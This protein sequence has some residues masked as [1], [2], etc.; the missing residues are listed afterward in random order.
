MSIETDL[1]SNVRSLQQ[2]RAEAKARAFA[3]LHARVLSGQE[4][5]PDAP[6]VEESWRLRSRK[7][8]LSAKRT[9][10]VG[11]MPWHHPEIWLWAASCAQGQEWIEQSVTFWESEVVRQRRQAARLL[12]R[13][14]AARTGDEGEYVYEEGDELL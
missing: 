3:E 2:H 12:E 6:H 8:Y 9:L 1:K 4:P 10:F 7:I 11:N 14:R 13:L 5:H